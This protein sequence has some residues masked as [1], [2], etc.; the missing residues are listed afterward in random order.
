VEPCEVLEAYDKL[1]L[2]IAG[3]G[4]HLAPWHTKLGFQ[5][6]PAIATLNSISSD[7][8][9]IPCLELIVTKVYPIAFIEFHK[10]AD[11]KVTREGPRREKDE[12]AAH[13]AWTKK[14][15][16]EYQRLRKD[17][18]DKCKQYIDWAQRFEA[19]SASWHPREDDD[20]PGHIESMFDECEDSS[21]ISP[22]LRRASKAEAGWLARF[23]RD[24]VEKERETLEQELERELQ[25]A[26]PPREVRSFCV[27]LMR[28]ARV[29]RRPANRVVELTAWDVLSLS[30]DGATA[31]RFKEGQR[32][33]IT[34]LLPTQKS[35][36]MDRQAEGSHVYVSSSKISR[37]TRF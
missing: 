15:D 10:D 23:T 28:D 6:Y 34:N 12:L 9:M 17:A 37:W 13:D 33:R 30:F 3:N 11:G 35:A 27:L 24:R 26:C 29:A 18:D 19:K 8:G 1:E 4:T 14:R 25:A 7:G 32:F 2:T 21:D 5:P 31:G 16:R 36:W 20:M 22:V